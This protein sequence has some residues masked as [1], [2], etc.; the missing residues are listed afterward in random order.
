MGSFQAQHIAPANSKRNAN[1]PTTGTDRQIQ[2][3]DRPPRGCAPARPGSAAGLRAGVLGG[4][5]GRRVAHPAV[6]R[7]RP[8]PAPA[9]AHVPPMFLPGVRLDQGQRPRLRIFLRDRPSP[10]AP[11][12]RRE[13]TG[14]LQRLHD[15]TRGAGR[16]PHLQQR[17]ECCPGGHPHRHACGG[18]P[19]PRG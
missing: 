19:L 10:G 2:A 7:L 16:P 5:A 3:N 14:P 12:H 15:R 6:F 17:P 13:G 8:V 18:V 4:H 1:D 9:H 11:C